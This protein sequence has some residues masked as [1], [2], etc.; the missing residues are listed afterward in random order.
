MQSMRL[1]SSS[2]EDVSAF[3]LPLVTATRW[4]EIKLDIFEPK[5]RIYAEVEVYLNLPRL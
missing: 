1:Y 5:I 2:H 4:L 3:A